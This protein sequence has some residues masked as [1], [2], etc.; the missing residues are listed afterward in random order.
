MKSK[1]TDGLYTRMKKANSSE[2]IAKLLEAGSS[3]KLAMPGYMDK[4]KGL[5]K[6]R[7]R[8]LKKS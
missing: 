4:L 2:E 8:E 5:A 6:R 7:S 3:Y 1:N